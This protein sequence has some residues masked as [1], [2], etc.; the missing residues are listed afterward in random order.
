MEMNFAMQLY[1][2]FDYFALEKQILNVFWHIRACYG[3]KLF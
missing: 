3:K 1:T 2:C